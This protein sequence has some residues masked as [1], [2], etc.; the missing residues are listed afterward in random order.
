MASRN[1]LNDNVKIEEFPQE[2]S[3]WFLL[4]YSKYD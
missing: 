3:T 4:A 1:F 2:V